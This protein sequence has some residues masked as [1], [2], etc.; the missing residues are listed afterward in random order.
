M[1]YLP[2]NYLKRKEWIED[3]YPLTV[4]VL[5]PGVIRITDGDKRLDLYKRRY[6]KVDDKVRFDLDR[7]KADQLIQNYFDVEPYY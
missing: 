2:I 5:T 1:S 4:I 7:S 3:K 6:F